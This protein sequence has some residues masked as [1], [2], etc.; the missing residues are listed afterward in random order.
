VPQWLFHLQRSVYRTMRTKMTP[1]AIAL[2]GRTLASGGS[3]RAAKSF[4]SGLLF[5]L[6]SASLLL[7]GGLPRPK[8]PSAGI[9]S[10]WQAIGKDMT[11]AMRK[12]G[13]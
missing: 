3:P 1:R 4:T 8:A 9:S 7:A 6:S 13:R 2:A 10:D 11:G 12:H 5:G